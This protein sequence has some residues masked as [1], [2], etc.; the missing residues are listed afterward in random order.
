MIRYPSAPLSLSTT[1][2]F[3]TTFLTLILLS[4]AIRAEEIN[5][6]WPS[7]LV[8]VWEPDRSYCASLESERKAGSKM[9][10]ANPNG[11]DVLRARMDFYSYETEGGDCEILSFNPEGLGLRAEAQCRYEEGA[12]QKAS[13]LLELAITGDILSLQRSGETSPDRY[14][15]CPSQAKDPNQEIIDKI[16]ILTQSVSLGKDLFRSCNNTYLLTDSNISIDQNTYNII[17]CETSLQYAFDF[18]NFIYD[19][20]NKATQQVCWKDPVNRRKRVDD[21][22]SFLEKIGDLK[23]HSSASLLYAFAIE[24]YKC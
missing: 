18:A 15:R 8:G 3:S 24:Y 9:T 5:I 22:T 1:T 13:F 11:K 14:Y 23:T 21:F 17:S 10:V 7:S 20:S 2:L 4:P 12:Y 6:Y 16:L 19:L